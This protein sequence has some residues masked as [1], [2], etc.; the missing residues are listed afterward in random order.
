GSIPNREAIVEDLKEFL[1]VHPGCGEPDSQ[2]NAQTNQEV[3]PIDG[4]STTDND[5]VLQQEDPCKDTDEHVWDTP[6]TSHRNNVPDTKT[7]KNGMSCNIC[8]K[9]F[10]RKHNLKNHMMTHTSK[11]S[12]SCTKCHAWFSNKWTLAR[13]MKLHTGNFPYSC[14]ICGKGCIFALHLEN[15]MRTHTKEKPYICK[16]CNKRFSQKSNLKKHEHLH[17]KEKSPSCSLGHE[18]FKYKSNCKKYLEKHAKYSSTLSEEDGLCPVCNTGYNSRC[19]LLGHMIIHETPSCSTTANEC[20]VV[21][22]A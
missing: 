18:K 11:K 9:S 13:H 16:T 6:S 14:E 2:G 12:I 5:E 22:H 17:G 3:L 20:S 7:N 1:I 19:S 10:N 4:T 15:H 21:E 8:S